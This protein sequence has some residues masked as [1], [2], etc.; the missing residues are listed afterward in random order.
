MP[1]LK[2]KKWLAARKPSASFETLAVPFREDPGAELPH[3][4]SL[5]FPGATVSAIRLR[6][7]WL[8]GA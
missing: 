7:G 3:Q 8:G 2:T 5:P 4:L 1:R 6:R